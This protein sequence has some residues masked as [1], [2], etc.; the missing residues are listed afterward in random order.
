LPPRIRIPI[1]GKSAA[2]AILCAFLVFSWQS[3]TV[4]CNYGGNWTALFLTGGRLQ[5]PPALAN[6]H[7]YTFPGS[8]GWDGQFYHYIAHDPLM[9]HDLWKYIDAPRLRYRRILI[10]AL[11][12]ALAC[13]N[14]VHVDTAY[15]AVILLFFA[16]GAYWLSRLAARFGRRRAWG[17]AFLAIPAAIVSMDRMAVDVGLAALVM[18]FAWYSREEHPGWQLYPV[19][20][21]G[22]LARD[23]GLLLVP[24]YCI[25]LL[26]HKRA[27]RAAAFATAAIPTLAWYGY[28]DLRTQ[29][30]AHSGPIAI[31]FSGLLDRLL[32]AWPYPYSPGL[33]FALDGLDDLAVVGIL[34]AIIMAMPLARHTGFSPSGWAM[35]LFALVG[36]FLWRPGDWL[37]AFDYA[38]ILSPLLALVALETLP[39]FRWLMWA[40]LC[41]AAPRCLIQLAP[42]VLGVLRLAVKVAPPH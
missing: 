3:L 8:M 38:R 35:V 19:L 23:T 33:R 4:R 6:E 11:A 21:L 36:I 39:A 20:L 29:P 17:L 22:A 18:G 31:P 24:A 9:A 13:G 27:W 25:W 2:W 28:I 1:D 12:Y 10:P 26:M 32:H 40:P 30:F 7:I 15:R 41:M 14:P 37:E 16:L 34:L 5:I 42:Q